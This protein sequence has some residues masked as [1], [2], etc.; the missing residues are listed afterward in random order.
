MF[1]LATFPANILFFFCPNFLVITPRSIASFI[2]PSNTNHVQTGNIKISGSQ[3]Y[4]SSISVNYNLTMNWQLPF[5]PPSNVDLFWFGW[6]CRNIFRIL[7]R[8]YVVLYYFTSQ[9]VPTK[10]KL[11]ITSQIDKPKNDWFCKKS[12]QFL[13][14]KRDGYKIC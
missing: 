1:S 7:H 14:H 13:S 9:Q 10:F 11:K 12:F 4:A 8:T 5:D 2:H 3:I 6:Y